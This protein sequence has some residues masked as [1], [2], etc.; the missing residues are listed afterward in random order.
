VKVASYSLPSGFFSVTWHIQWVR[1][2]ETSASNFRGCPGFVV[3]PRDAGSM[4]LLAGETKALFFGK[5]ELE[6]FPQE[7]TNAAP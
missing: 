3:E 6:P 2:R 4:V 1:V 5:G 7:A